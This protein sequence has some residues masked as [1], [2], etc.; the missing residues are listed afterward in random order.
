MDDFDR[1]LEQELSRVLD[2]VVSTPAPRRSGSWHDGRR[3]RGLRTLVG[4]LPVDGPFPILAPEPIPVPV[5]VVIG[6]PSSAG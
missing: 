1:Y 5:S 3:G 2:P 4:G 6:A